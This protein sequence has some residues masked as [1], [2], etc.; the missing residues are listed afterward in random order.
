MTPE[1]R[2]LYLEFTMGLGDDEADRRLK[3]I[4]ARALSSPVQAMLDSPPPRFLDVANPLPGPP[5]VA[6]S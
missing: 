1:Q 6:T 4:V 3:A 5:D 2:L